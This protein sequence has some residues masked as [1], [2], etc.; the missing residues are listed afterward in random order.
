MTIH[1]YLDGPDEKEITTLHD[2]V[3]NPFKVGDEISLSVYEV[4]PADV[5]KYN[6]DFQMKIY[7]SSNELIENFHREKIRILREG[8]YMTL[9]IMK[10]PIIEIEYHC[11]LIKK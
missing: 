4:Y 1:F 8:K 3:S 11:E 9:K 2:M 5:S 6:E 10:A 7:E